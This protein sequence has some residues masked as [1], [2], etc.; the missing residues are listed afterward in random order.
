MN[1]EQIE[2]LAKKIRIKSTEI[3][4][5]RILTD[6]EAA[7]QKS[8]QIKSAKD[9][10]KIWRTIIKSRIFNSRKQHPHSVIKGC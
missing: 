1:P 6:A 10:S 9:E 3:D 4:H 2:R 5:E 8:K 7:L